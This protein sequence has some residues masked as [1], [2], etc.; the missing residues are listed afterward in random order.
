MGLYIVELLENDERKVEM[1]LKGSKVNCV[2]NL[3][4]DLFVVCT[5]DF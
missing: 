3:E 2:K 4:K 5:T 1:H